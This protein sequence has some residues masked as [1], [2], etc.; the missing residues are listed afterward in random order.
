MWLF[1]LLPMCSVWLQ[2]TAN[3]S[4][5]LDSNVFEYIKYQK[6]N[7]QKK[8]QKNLI[9]SVLP[10]KTGTVFPKDMASSE[11]TLSGKENYTVTALNNCF[12]LL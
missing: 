10:C 4:F 6:R 9:A 2:Q 5:T 11:V 1:S 3:H 7:I 12:L 8:N